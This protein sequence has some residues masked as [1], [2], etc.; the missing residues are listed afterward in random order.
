MVSEQILILDIGL[1]WYR[2]Q[3]VL[4]VGDWGMIALTAFFADS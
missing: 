3:G 1:Q 2:V 4:L